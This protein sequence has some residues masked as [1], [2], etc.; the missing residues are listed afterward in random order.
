MTDRPA[1]R[2]LSL[3]EASD[4]LGVHTSTL[5]RWADSGRVGCRRTPG[6]H[7]RFSLRRLQPFLEG[8]DPDA[9]RRGPARADEQPW[10]ARFQAAGLVPDLRAL[11]QRLS[12]LLLQYVL[13]ADATRRHLD[14]CRAL[15]TEYARI[16]RRAGIELLDAVEAF[17]F[18]RASSAELLGGGN[19]TDSSDG[20]R[21]RYDAFMSQVLLGLVDGYA[22]HQN[23]AR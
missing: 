2:W 23:G 17:L 7:R 10:H 3:R 12:G 19:A 8:D 5:R 16:S 1:E 18:F 15:G 13:R 20:T 11:G 4:L 9:A 22:G 6:G 21:A 14:D